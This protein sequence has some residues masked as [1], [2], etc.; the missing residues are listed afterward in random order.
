MV[1]QLTQSAPAVSA[2]LPGADEPLSLKSS[3][4]LRQLLKR[5]EII[6]APGVCDGIS[7]RC[8]LEAGFNVLYQRQVPIIAFNT[9]L[10]SYCSIWQRIDSRVVVQW[11]CDNRLQARSA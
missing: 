7:A 2:V 9:V 5:P 11:S 4:R 1:M 3:T 6:I 8:A 10:L